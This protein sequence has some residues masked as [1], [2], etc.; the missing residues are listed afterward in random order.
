MLFEPTPPEPQP[1]LDGI[2]PIGGAPS[3]SPPSVG[4][5]PAGAPGEGVP[6]A[7]GP[8]Q[9]GRGGRGGNGRGGTLRLVVGSAVLSAILAAGSTVAILEV[10]SP[11][12]TS[13][14]G[15]ASSASPAASA[16]ASSASLQLATGGSSITDIVAT[17]QASVVTVRTTDTG[18]GGQVSGEGAGSGIVVSANGLILTNDHVISGASTISVDLADGRTVTATVVTTNTAADLAIIKADATGLTPAKLGD[19]STLK[20]GEGV[21]AIGTPLGVYPGTVTSGIISA[22]D[23][24]ITAGTGRSGGGGEQ[25]SGLIQTDAAMN[26]GNSGGPLLD[27]QGNVIGINTAVS[28]SAAGL[29]FAIPIN[30]AK[31]LIAQ[32][33]GSS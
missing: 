22:L 30:A 6:S 4:W 7:P 11:A 15:P 33:I 8:A 32:A 12:A 21:I 18:F 31:S 1:P 29:G 17:A 26:P 9:A 16:P 14:A 25:L 23:R 27:D 3:A 24:S 10:A 28:G 20:V 5:W 13:T 2:P 19:S